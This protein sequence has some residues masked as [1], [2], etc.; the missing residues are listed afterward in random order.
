MP[1]SWVYRDEKAISLPFKIR[2]FRFCICLLNFW[3]LFETSSMPPSV[4]MNGSCGN[5]KHWHFH[6]LAPQLGTEV[7]ANCKIPN[8]IFLNSLRDIMD[9]CWHAS[10]FFLAIVSPFPLEWLMWLLLFVVCELTAWLV[11]RL[12]QGPSFHISL[13]VV[14]YVVSDKIVSGCWENS[15]VPLRFFHGWTSDQCRIRENKRK[16]I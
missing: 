4:N 14:F 6:A 15:F 7:S 1:S 3:V 10:S 16:F 13:C 11:A 2:R 12:W 9:T 5:M 8:Q